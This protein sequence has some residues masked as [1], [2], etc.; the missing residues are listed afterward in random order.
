MEHRARRESNPRRGAVGPQS[1]A[2]V[3]QWD[4]AAASCSRVE[5]RVP[6]ARG[7]GPDAPRRVEMPV[8]LEPTSRGPDNPRPSARSRGQVYGEGILMLWPLS[9]GTPV[10]CESGGR[11]SHPLRG[12]HIPSCRAAYTTPY[13]VVRR[14]QW[15]LHPHPSGRQPDAPLL[16]P[17]PRIVGRRRRDGVTAR[18]GGGSRV[19]VHP[20]AAPHRPAAG[21]VSCRYCYFVLP[22]T[23]GCQTA[24]CRH[25]GAGTQHAPPGARRRRGV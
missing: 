4:R 5:L 6:A 8:G 15:D 12:G 1:P 18:T 17:W 25:G 19:S 11:V 2:L 23:V 3:G 7:K 24:S 14:D 21:H 13:R 20:G 10:C 9:Y 22:R 16:E